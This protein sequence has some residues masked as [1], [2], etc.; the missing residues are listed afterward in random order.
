MKSF[1]ELIPKNL[2]KMFWNIKDF[3]TENKRT[4]I[5]VGL[6]LVLAWCISPAKYQKPTKSFIETIRNLSL[7]KVASLAVK[8]LLTSRA[9]KFNLIRPPEKLW[10]TIRPYRND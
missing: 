9:R 5:G 3:I 8:H 6:F 2:N 7:P 10:L 4:Q 1:N